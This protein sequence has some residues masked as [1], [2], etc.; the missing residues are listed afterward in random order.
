MHGTPWARLPTVLRG[1]D[2]SLGV[3]P[4]KAPGP[5]TSKP[6]AAL[7]IERTVR[8]G[9]TIVCKD[10]DVVVVGAV[11]SGAEVI[12]GGSIHVYGA[13]RGRA[14]AGVRTGESARIFCRSLQAELVAIGGVYRFAETWDADVRRRAAQIRREGRA[15]RLTV[16]E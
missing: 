9:Q 10:G 11:A 3:A 13:L 14:I 4:R 8:S 2:T 5:P 12:A 1:R 15:L 16:L 7:L 6:A